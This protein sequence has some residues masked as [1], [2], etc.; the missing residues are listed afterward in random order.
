MFRSGRAVA[1][2]LVGLVCAALVV[3]AFPANAA[4]GPGVP[5]GGGNPFAAG[6]DAAARLGGGVIG[7]VGDAISGALGGDGDLARSAAAGPEKAPPAERVRELPGERTAYSRVFEM[8]DGEF[9]AEVFADPVHYRDGN[10]KW[11]E[12]D[13][14]VTPSGR[15]GFAYGSTGNRFGTFFGTRSD[16]LVRFELGDRFVTVGLLGE[17]R[18]LNPLVD[19]DTVTYEDVF[20]SADLRYRVTAEGLKEEIVLDKAPESAEF[21]FTFTLGGVTAETL[22]DGSIGFFDNDDDS[23]PLFTIPR[24]FMYDSAEDEGSATGRGWSDAV[25]L[26]VDQHGSE[27]VVTLAADEE[28]LSDEDRVYPAMVDPT[29]E[30]VPNPDSA[31]D[32]MIL[33]TAPSTNYGE[34]TR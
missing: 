20:G 2:W 29:I 31:Q 11:R 16:R 25:D 23:V 13:T 3:T 28:W 26:A 4:A 6:W 30:L 5:S 32:A 24:P 33:Q 12:I 15:D 7:T 14:A 8:S 27:T 17:R 10:G 9:E 22:N 34:S 1:R 18:E 21:S 19:G